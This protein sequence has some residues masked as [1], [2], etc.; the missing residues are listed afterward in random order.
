MLTEAAAETSP[1]HKRV[2]AYNIATAE[3]ALGDSAAVIDR[4]ETLIDEY[5]GV[6]GITPRDV[7]GRNAPDLLKIIPDAKQDVDTFKH[8]ADSLDVLAKA[9]DQEG[10][11]SPFA[12]IHAL[13]FYDLARAPESIFRVGQ[14]L[15]DQFLGVRDF[16][17]AR[18]FMESTLL[19]QLQQFKIADYVIPVRS[20]YAVVLAYCGNFPDAERE[21]ARL[22]PYEAGLGLR[23][24]MELAQQR[25]LIAELHRRGPPPAFILPTGKLEA[26]RERMRNRDFSDLE[27][28]PQR[29]PAKIG[30]NEQCPCGSGKKYKVCHGRA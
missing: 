29:M 21:M 3:L 17:G 7:M 30:R 9:M 26:I 4:V 11:F 18:E 22:Q 23:E 14:D 19:P 24:K 8:L 20:Q 15:V 1:E 12:R 28:A 2:L 10:Q 16:E 27:L 5:F 13:K 6:I 25:R